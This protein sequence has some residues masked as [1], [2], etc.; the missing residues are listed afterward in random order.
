MKRKI[1]MMELVT[2]MIILL[3]GLL[4]YGLSVHKLLPIPH[5]DLVAVSTIGMILIVTGLNRFV[6]KTKEMEIEKKDER[7]VAI[8]N[9]SMA[10][11][12]KSMTT[13]LALAL[14]VLIFAGYMNPVSCFSIISVLSIGQITCL[15]KLYYL[16]K[17]M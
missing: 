10:S 16:E 5:P 3:G 11:G 15:I 13:M 1:L 7:N 4:I 8:A 17:H 12:F 9:A 14:F 6:K 2:A